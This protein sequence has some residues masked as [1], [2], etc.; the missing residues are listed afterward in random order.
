MGK[1][2]RGQ[3]WIY[4]LFMVFIGLIIAL[5]LAPTLASTQANAVSNVTLFPSGSIEKTMMGMIP[6]VFVAAVLIAAMVMLNP[7]NRSEGQ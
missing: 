5:N 1:K 2:M 6:W 3:V 7:M 4:T